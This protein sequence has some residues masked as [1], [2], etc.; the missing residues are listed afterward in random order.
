MFLRLER[1]LWIHI[2]NGDANCSR[3]AYLYD[4]HVAPEM[5]S[6]QLVKLFQS[7]SEI[8]K[9]KVNAVVRHFV[10]ER[11]SSGQAQRM[12]LYRTGS[13]TVRSRLPHSQLGSATLRCVPIPLPEIRH[14]S[15]RRD[16]VIATLTRREIHLLDRAE[17]IS[18]DGI[19]TSH[20]ES[21]KTDTQSTWSSL[22]EYDVGISAPFR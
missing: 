8:I 1:Q 3:S 6:V 15:V 9:L 12:E 22:L 2:R 11:D 10:D 20:S 4:A 17:K 19:I 21:C 5:H 14:L 7:V 13:G 16:S 18:D